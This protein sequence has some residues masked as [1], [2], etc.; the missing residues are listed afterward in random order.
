MDKQAQSHVL[1][2]A[3]ASDREPSD[4]LGTASNIKSRVN[5]QSVLG[6]ITSTLWLCA[7]SMAALASFLAA[8]HA[9]PKSVVG[10]M[11]ACEAASMLLVQAHC[12]RANLEEAAVLGPPP[13]PWRSRPRTGTPRANRLFTLRVLPLRSARRR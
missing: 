13:R 4:E 3:P 6:A 9:E 1:S 2:M 8:M 5:R 10:M 12:T 7:P 11:A